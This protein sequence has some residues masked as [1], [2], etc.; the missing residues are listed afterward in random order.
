MLSA[1][2]RDFITEG[3][4]RNVRADGRTRVDIRKMC[5]RG[6]TDVLVGVKVEVG[7]VDGG[8]SSSS[9]DGTVGTGSAGDEDEG[10]VDAVVGGGEDQVRSRRRGDRGRVECHVQCSAGAM[11]SLDPRQVEVMCR[12]YADIMTRMFNGDHGG[13]DLK[14]L[15]IVPGSTC[16]VVYVDALILGYGGNILDPLFIAANGALRNTLIP[17][18]SVEEA[19]GRYEFDVADEETEVLA[20][21][22]NV[23]AVVTLHKI[24]SRYVVDPSYLE[25]LC[26]DAR[27]TVAVNKKGNLCGLEKGGM[28]S[29]NAGL[30]LELIGAAKS[31]ATSFFLAMDEAFSRELSR[32]NTREDPVGFK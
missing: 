6:G 10:R 4:A 1:V 32:I 9:G 20:G 16:W 24:G 8:R 25:E 13:L 2:E 14:A 23:P 3:V 19:G 26:A 27:L 12:E 22:E 28:G 31:M 18:C 11:K 15:S 21:V 5:P 7:T 17:K 30:L 29:M